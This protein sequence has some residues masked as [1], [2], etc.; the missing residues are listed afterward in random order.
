MCPQQKIFSAL[1]MRHRTA[2]L[3]QALYWILT[4]VPNSFAFT[5]SLLADTNQL[6]TP[7][8]RSGLWSS[9]AGSAVWWVTY[10]SYTLLDTTRGIQHVLTGT[11]NQQHFGFNASGAKGKVLESFDMNQQANDTYK[12]SFGKNPVSV[13]DLLGVSLLM[14]APLITSLT[15]C[16]WSIV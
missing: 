6:C 5:P 12:L 11:V 3:P 10:L 2:I 8:Q 16:P 4:C 13:T 7:W 15:L 9:S 1:Q 14:V